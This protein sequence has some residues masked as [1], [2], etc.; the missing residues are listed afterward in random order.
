[1]NFCFLNAS[2]GFLNWTRII[3][4]IITLDTKIKLEVQSDTTYE[5]YASP[6]SNSPTFQAM[7][8]DSND[9]RTAAGTHHVMIKSVTVKKSIQPIN[10]AFADEDDEP[11]GPHFKRAKLISTGDSTSLGWLFSLTG[12]FNNFKNIKLYY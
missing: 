12:W 2:N 11:Q 4:Y 8:V 9:S 5:A 10:Q 3:I 6:N 7:N 1:M